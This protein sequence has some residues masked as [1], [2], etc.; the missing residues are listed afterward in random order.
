[1]ETEWHLSP[2]HY[3]VYGFLVNITVI[4][5]ILSWYWQGVTV[6]VFRFFFHFFQVMH[7]G[8]AVMMQFCFYCRKL[9]IIQLYPLSHSVSVL[10]PFP[11]T[12]PGC[13]SSSFP[14]WSL[15]ICPL[16]TELALLI[17]NI[18]NDVTCGTVLFN[19]FPISSR[20]PIRRRGYPSTG[21]PSRPESA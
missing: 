8:C 9:S 3:H 15:Y 21:Q 4:P 2:H 16:R 13:F 11:S 1:M 20:V 19:T 7:A 14:S 5:I 12:Q 6:A 10:S 18:V 17:K